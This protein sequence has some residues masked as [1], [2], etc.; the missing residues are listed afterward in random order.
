MDETIAE[1]LTNVVAAQPATPSV[2]DVTTKVE[3]VKA[4]DAA[5]RELLCLGWNTGA[6]VGTSIGMSRKVAD[7]GAMGPFR[8]AELRMALLGAGSNFLPLMALMF[9]STFAQLNI[10]SGSAK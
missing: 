10:W 7:E 2:Q 6:S 8:S 3:V 1:E 4:V 5:T 9:S